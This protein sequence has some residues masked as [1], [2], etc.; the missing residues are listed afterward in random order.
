MIKVQVKIGDE[1][2]EVTSDQLPPEVI[3]NLGQAAGMMGIFDMMEDTKGKPI[4][5]YMEMNR[6]Y[7]AVGRKA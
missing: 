2:K 5:L 1:V 3:A 4:E 6:V 7:V